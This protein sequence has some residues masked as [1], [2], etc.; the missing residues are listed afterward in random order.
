[1]QASN[2][3]W[4]PM[5]SRRRAPA[6]SSP[7]PTREN[8]KTFYTPTKDEAALKELTDSSGGME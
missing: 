4:S 1:M 6:E 8:R 5:Q 7:G 3:G 2:Q